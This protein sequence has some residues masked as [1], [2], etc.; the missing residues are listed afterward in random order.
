MEETEL[1][2]EEDVHGE[3]ARAAEDDDEGEEAVD[4]EAEGAGDVAVDGGGGE[5]RGGGAERDAQGRARGEGEEICCCTLAVGVRGAEGD[6]TEGRGAEA[7]TGER[8]EDG[9][10]RGNV[11][12]EVGEERDTHDEEDDEEPRRT[13]E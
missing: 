1:E 11:R 8:G 2:E 4:T 9:C 3:E 6:E 7:T 10:T 12:G 13:D 5:R